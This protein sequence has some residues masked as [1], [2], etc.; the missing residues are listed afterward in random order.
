MAI[1]PPR[2]HGHPLLFYVY[3]RHDDSVSHLNV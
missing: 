2:L 3:V 1:D